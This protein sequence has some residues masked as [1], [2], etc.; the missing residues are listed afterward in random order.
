MSTLVWLLLLLVTLGFVSYRKFSL[1]VATGLVGTVLLLAIFSGDLPGPL[2]FLLL[3][4]FTVLALLFNVRTLSQEW[5]SRH[6]LPIYRRKLPILSATEREAMESGGV[7]WEAD[8]LAGK[9]DWKKLLQYPSSQLSAEEKAF[10]DG[11]VEEFCAMLDDWRIT[12][13]HLDLPP[14]AWAF[15]K[16][17]GFMGLIVPREYGGL[18]FSARATSELVLKIS[19]RSITAACNVLVPNSL[20]PAKL[21]L[22]YGT[23]AQKQ[24]Y[25]PRLAS[26]E[27][28]PCFALT[29]PEVGSDASNMPDIGVVCRQRV[30]GEEVLGLRLNWN[31][32][33]LTLGPVATVIGL[34]FRLQDPEHLLGDQDEL[35]ITVALI[36]SATPGVTA[37]RRHMPLNIPF[38]N[39]PIQG[40]DVFV[41]LDSVIGGEAG[42]GKGWMMLVECLSEGRGM[43]LPALSSAGCKSVS[44]YTGAYARIREQFHAS[45]GNFEGVREALARIG[46]LTYQAD[47]ARLLTLAAL[48][49]GEKPGVVSAIA[50]YHLTEMMREVVNRGMDIQGGS[51][52][53]LGPR[54][55]IGRVYQGL[56]ISIT[57]EGANILTRSLMIFGQ[58][59]IR[60]HPW[61]LKE[62]AAANQ[63]DAGKALVDF[64]LALFGHLGHAASNF[65]RSLFL[66][67]TSGRGSPAPAEKAIKDLAQKLNWMSA[68]LAITTEFALLRYGGELKRKEHLSG[69]LGDILSHLYLA[70]ATLKH[71]QDQGC[72]N[73]D[74]PLVRWSCNQSLWQIQLAFAAI[75]ANFPSRFQ[76]RLMKA[77]AFPTG[78][79]LRPP[80][81]LLT[82]Q[83]ADLLLYPS[84][85]RERLT[86]G[87]Y[88]ST[89]L[90]E[91]GARLDAALELVDEVDKIKRKIRKAQKNGPPNPVS[92]DTGRFANEGKVIS[93]SEAELLEKYEALRREIIQVDDFSAEEFA[94]G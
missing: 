66:G 67:L 93:E 74:L 32:R 30:Q 72:H 85:S 51:G 65:C 24:H 76:A 22:H 62:M 43:S 70:S 19:S 5:I 77:I 92:S 87:I 94:S 58:G 84:P 47:A 38:Q 60:A 69:R 9:P 33:Y 40:Q 83:V 26:G 15:M 52:I 41:P 45:I 54:N 75:F 4:A 44:R 28:L 42:I 80:S 25:L 86:A 36:P 29:G 46:G 82:Y 55:L 23:D 57:V 78:M 35:G 21:L 7:W 90:T 20:G 48:D 17:K 12:H 56:P 13:R 8:L 73:K 91:P 53:M 61:L 49:A 79:R 31:K 63:A 34:A 68:A 1:V 27:E 2:S 37:G 64:D 3:L 50:K 88:T 16:E 10:L 71:F 6:L 59:V 81:D 89:D 39:G 14:E 18:G 11:P